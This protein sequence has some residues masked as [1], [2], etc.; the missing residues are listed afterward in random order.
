MFICISKSR[1]SQFLFVCQKVLFSKRKASDSFL[2]FLFYFYIQTHSN[3]LFSLNWC[4]FLCS[5]RNLFSHQKNCGHSSVWVNSENRG[6]FCLQTQLHF[7]L[8]FTCFPSFP[9]STILHSILLPLS[10]SKA[11]NVVYSKLGNEPGLQG[12]VPDPLLTFRGLPGAGK[13]GHLGTC[14]LKW[15]S[16]H[17]NAAEGKKIRAKADWLFNY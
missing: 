11:G 7:Y 13:V 15:F 5:L 17:S 10:S 16:K 9:C 4:I 2:F 6:S 3:H 12:D 14:V 1:V 8:P